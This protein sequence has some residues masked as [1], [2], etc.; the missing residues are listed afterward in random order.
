MAGLGQFINGDIGKGIG[1]LVTEFALGIASGIA[2][3]AKKA[4]L[5]FGAVAAS[6]IPGV[7]SIVDAVKNAKSESVQ[8][9]NK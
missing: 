4:G 6:I 8:I 3:G 9:V 7:W 1:F 2:F 5:G